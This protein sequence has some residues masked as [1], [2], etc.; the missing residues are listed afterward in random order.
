VQD[1][2]RLF[3]YAAT[4]CR[5]INRHNPEKQLSFVL[6][7]NRLHIPP[8]RTFPR[9][10]LDKM[11]S[12][13]LTSSIYRNYDEDE[14]EEVIELFKQTVGPVIILSDILSTTALAS[15]LA[16]PTRDV[17]EILKHI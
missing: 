1:A 3:I 14:R 17:D 11:Y 8:L 12:Q 13:V 4:I 6:P 16:L 15:L 10:N 2:N 9:K 5:F 7:R